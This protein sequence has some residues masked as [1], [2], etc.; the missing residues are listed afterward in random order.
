[1]KLTAMLDTNQQLQ[2]AGAI[3]ML[4]AFTMAQFGWL[5]TNSRIYLILNLFGASI[6]AVLAFADQQ[7][8]FL[9]LEGV[10]AIVS[11]ISLAKRGL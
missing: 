7:W 11:A 4:A 1:M 8:G 10:W 9:L 2:I 5:P 3:M 6:L